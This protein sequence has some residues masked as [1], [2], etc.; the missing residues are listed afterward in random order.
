VL[1]TFLKCSIKIACFSRAQRF[2][3]RKK[4]IFAN[5]KGK[6]SILRFTYERL[7]ESCARSESTRSSFHYRA[8]T[9]HALFSPAP[10]QQEY[11]EKKRRRR[12]IVYYAVPGTVFPVMLLSTELVPRSALKNAG[13]GSFAESELWSQICDNAC[14]RRL[15]DVPA[16]LNSSS[17]S[18]SQPE[19][20]RARSP[21]SSPLQFR[22]TGSSRWRNSE[23]FH[24]KCIRNWLSINNRG[25][26]SRVATLPLSLSGQSDIFS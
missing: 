6:K 5:E 18:R 11:Q 16:S 12:A 1:T 23:N 22:Y 20:A 25:R 21:Y 19:A 3:R 10:G 7:A 17:Q 8:L 2:L 15:R 26:T 4:W 13:P 24:E 9:C 14:S